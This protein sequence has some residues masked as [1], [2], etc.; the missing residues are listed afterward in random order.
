LREK[1]EKEGELFKGV[2]GFF[3]QLFFNVLSPAPI[4]TISPSFF[5]K[6]GMC[7]AVTMK[8]RGFS[9]ARPLVCNLLEDHETRR[10]ICL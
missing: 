1:V 4:G 2:P 9:S 7:Q 3:S 6:L 8:L 5:F 10:A